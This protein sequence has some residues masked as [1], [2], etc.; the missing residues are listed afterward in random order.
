M[1]NPDT[2]RYHRTLAAHSQ[3][4]LA[5]SVGLSPL[6]IKRIEDGA[7]A[8]RLPLAVIVRITEALNLTIDQLLTSPTSSPDAP[9]Q[10]LSDPGALTYQQARLLRRIQRGQNV[11]R[12]LTKADRELTLPFLMRMGLVTTTATG[13][14]LTEPAGSSLQA[15]HSAP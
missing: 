6:G 7:D 2:L 3:R 14:E 9:E 4:S 8:S 5:K 11:T 1:I 10:P 12:S 13:L 15:I